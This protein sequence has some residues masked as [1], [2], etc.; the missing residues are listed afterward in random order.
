MPRR[1]RA[2][3]GNLS[4]YADLRKRIFEHIFEQRVDF[5]NGKNFIAGKKRDIHGAILAVRR[6]SC[7]TRKIC[8]TGTETGT[9]KP[10]K[11]T[12]MHTRREKSEDALAALKQ[13][14]NTA[15]GRTGR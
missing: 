8:F 13:N 7:N 4:F 3:I 15:D 1:V 12:N 2:V 5:G 10:A 9:A 6:K 14:G 11:F